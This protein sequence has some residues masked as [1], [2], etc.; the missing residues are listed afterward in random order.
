MDIETEYFKNNILPLKQKLFRKALYITR[1]QAEAED[2]VQEAMMRMWDNRREWPN[3]RNIESFCSLLVRNFAI[4]RIKQSG[5]RYETI[6]ADRFLNVEASGELPIENLILT[7]EKRV[8]LSVI[9]SL[10][11]RQREV[12][13]LRELEDMSYKE[14]AA[15]LSISEAQVKILLFRARQSVKKIYQ[16]IAQYGL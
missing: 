2:I 3:I 10:P 9:S 4:D 12:I 8:V 16:K 7:D 14:I 13:R 15:E 5:F 6:D 1:S 11:E